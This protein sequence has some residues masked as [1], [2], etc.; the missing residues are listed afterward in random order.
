MDYQ[1]IYNQIID[2]ARSETRM[3]KSVVFYEAHHIIPKCLGGDGKTSEWKW[4]PNIIL[5]TPREHF[6]CHKL[7]C[8]IYPNQSKLI[9]AYWMMSNKPTRSSNTRNYNI[10]NREYERLRTKISELQH[11][12]H[13]GTKRTDETKRKL[14]VA[15]RGKRSTDETKRKISDAQRG[16]P[17]SD[18]TKRKM[19]LAKLG[20]SITE[21]HKQKISNATKGRI[22]TE[23]HKQKI[24]EAHLNKKNQL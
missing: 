18:E 10:G 3:K 24:R 8:E 19:R 6:I 11:L 20:K 16:K 12:N 5:L 9:F 1:K 17:K 2:K 13:I 7:L 15:Q 21:E 22:F 14:S 4:H 23:E